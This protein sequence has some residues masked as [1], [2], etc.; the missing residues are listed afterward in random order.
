MLHH[1]SP[2][3]GRQMVTLAGTHLNDPHCIIPY[4]HWAR[5]YF[6]HFSVHC[7]ISS[8]PL[9]TGGGFAPLP[10][11]DPNAMLTQPN[12]SQ[13]SPKIVCLCVYM[14]SSHTLAFGIQIPFKFQFSSDALE[15]GKRLANIAANFVN[16]GEWFF[17]KHERS[18]LFSSC[19]AILVKFCQSLTENTAILWYLEAPGSGCDLS[20]LI[21]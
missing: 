12:I 6:L 3:W 14:W 4:R 1:T 20:Q 19:G 2:L 8:V 18:S 17:F 16:G 7:G 13:P 11:L 15:E 9:N 21:N 10:L 5:M